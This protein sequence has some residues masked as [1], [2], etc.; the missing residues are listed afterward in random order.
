MDYKKAQSLK[1]KSLLSLMAEKKFQEGQSIGSS[2]GGAISDKFKAKMTRT[3]EKFDPLNWV[4]G[5]T[6]SGVIGKSIRTMSGRAL[7]R[8]EEDI[9][10]FG[11]YQKKGKNKKDPKRTTIGKGPIKALKMGDST[12]DI[13]A[14]MYNFMQKTNEIALRNYEIDKKFREEQLEEDERRHKKLIES[15]TS[16]KTKQI[17]PLKEEEKE[18]KEPSW[19]NKLFS[20]MKKTITGLI[21]TL[22]SFILKPIEKLFSIV[23]GLT[24]LLG[25]LVE[26][27]AM[28]ILTIVGENIIPIFKLLFGPITKLVGS[29]LGT[30]GSLIARLIPGPIGAAIALAL[31]AYAE[32][33]VEEKSSGFLRSSDEYQKINDEKFEKQRQLENLS[34]GEY[35]S[36]YY[37]ESGKPET[38]KKNGKDYNISVG[39]HIKN[40]IKKYDDKLIGSL[41]KYEDETL[42]PAMKKLGFE[43][44]MNEGVSV[45]EKGTLFQI[46]EKKNEKGKY[47]DATLSD[48]AQLTTEV[49]KNKFENELKSGASGLF[50]SVK[51]TASEVKNQVLN[52]PDVSRFTNM[53]PDEESRKSY[54]EPFRKMIPEIITDEPQNTNQP[55]VTI[56]NSNNT[57]ASKENKI[58]DGNP[59]GVRNNNPSYKKSTM[60]ITASW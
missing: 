48:Y 60:G 15:L 29:M 59:L 50:D 41:K 53:I 11:G 39:D 52:S 34:V 31:G 8:S 1:N 35:N 5:L 17:E 19:V 25:G 10:Y 13:L 3:K 37:D 12:A 36:T 14:K 43:P 23:G 49:M 18:Q 44:K 7:G 51:K 22:S 47:E 6:G 45:R 24:T 42:T 40:E 4:K 20:S 21:G 9:S 32:K 16:K 2:V 58:E 30:T 55:I 57:S 26:S 46:Y 33:Q 54:I 38:G 28:S 27:L 56:Q